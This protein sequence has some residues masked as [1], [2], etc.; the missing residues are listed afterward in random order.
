MNAK[1]IFFYKI[2]HEGTHLKRQKSYEV[3]QTLK[4]KNIR[5]GTIFPAKLRMMH[6]ERDRI[7]ESPDEVKI[8][9]AIL[10]SGRPNM[11]KV[12]T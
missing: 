12:I 4:A 5:Y 8:S 9:F 6:T 2:L 11:G 7:F 3:K 1:Y 10:Q